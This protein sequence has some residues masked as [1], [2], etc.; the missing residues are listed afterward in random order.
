MVVSRRL[1]IN[2][3]VS[4]LASATAGPVWAS[5]YGTDDTHTDMDRGLL[6]RAL[7]ALEQHRDRIDFRDAI[8]VADF[9]KPSRA[10]RFHVVSLIE[11]TVRSYLVAHGRGSDPSH[12]GWLERF[13][14]EPHS[15]ATSDGAYRTGAMYV[16]A[17]GHSM[18]L[19][20]L[21]STNSN[22]L[23]RAIVVHS[24]WYVNERVIGAYGMLGRSQGCFAVADASLA[25]ITNRLGPGRLI[26]AGKA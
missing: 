9:S 20:G 1:F 19:E 2:L 21:D 7:R 4:G 3:A 14:N 22:A 15:N 12:T 18:R 5:A 26:Y 11:G 16:G 17:H 13:S 6:Q 25:D 10:P 24:A 23:S 8:G